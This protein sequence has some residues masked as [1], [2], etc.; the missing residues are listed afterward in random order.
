[1]NEAL[2]TLPPYP[3]V[4]LARRRKAREAQ[5]LRVYD[6]G[7]G[8]PIEPTAPMIREALCAAVG[9][10]SQYPAIA[11]SDA[12]RGSISTW[13]Q[14]RFGVRLSASDEIL[15][16]RGSK[17]GMFHL[18]L[19]C[20]DPGAARDTV[21]LPVPGYPVMKIGALYAHAKIHEV[22][23]HPG[24]DYVMRPSDVPDAVLARAALVWLNAPHNPTGQ[25][26]PDAAWQ[27]W[28]D[29]RDTHGFI[30]CS[31]ECYTEIYFDTPP[32]SLLEFGREGCLAF[33]SLS[34]RSGMTGYRSGFIAGDADLLASYRKQRAAMGQAQTAWV[35]AASVAAW[36]DET[37]VRA[38][39]RVFARK[40]AIVG[41]ALTA[42]GLP[43]FP[44]Q[45]TFYLWAPVPADTDDLAFAERLYEAGILLSPG[46][47]FGPGNESFV[48][49]ALVPSLED[50]ERAMDIVRELYE[51]EPWPACAATTPA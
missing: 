46:R 36:S 3:M 1:M 9:E 29:A 48:R 20:V 40:R 31:D 30:L 2:R 10:I 15:P 45:A 25:V 6:F 27:A 38:R 17:E 7:T 19:A 14:G 8:D 41:E 23:L 18:P 4:E 24:N 28:V 16:T 13:F 50:C 12:L 32:R 51:T 49:F 11:G 44:N 5:G 34:K 33:H 22:L 37:H 47:Y 26:L 35:D 39:R 42:L 43:P 21:V